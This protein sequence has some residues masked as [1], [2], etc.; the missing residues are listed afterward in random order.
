MN[1][2]PLLTAVLITSSALFITGCASDGHHR[3]GGEVI[4]D[5]AIT[6]K[7]K[8][9]LLAEKDIN[10]FDIKAETYDGTVQL[11]GFVD[12]QWQIDKAVQVAQAVG[13]VQRVKNDLVQKPK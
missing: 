8:A 11:S 5:A 6:T 9:A 3:S 13:G 2:K 4:D 12:S 10:S 1:L 7:V